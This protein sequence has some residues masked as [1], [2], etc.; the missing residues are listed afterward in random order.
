MLTSAKFLAKFQCF[1][2][3]ITKSMFSQ[4]IL[5]LNINVRKKV[6]LENVNTVKICGETLCFRQKSDHVT[7]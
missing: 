7:P 4:K 1:H 2:E 3:K 5:T 6:E